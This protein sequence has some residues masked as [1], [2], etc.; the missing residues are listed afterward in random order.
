[1]TSLER[2][3]FSAFLVEDHKLVR[4]GMRLLLNSDPQIRVMGEA[5]DAEDALAQLLRCQP[6]VVLIDLSLPGQSGTW[7][8]RQLRENRPDLRFLVVSM[9]DDPDSVIEAI[10]AGASGYIVKSATADELRAAVRAVASGGSFLH[11]E[12]A[13][14]V[15]RQ[16]RAPGD[17]PGPGEDP[18]LTAREREI[19]AIIAH[20]LNNRQMAERLHL[21]VSAVKSHLRSLFRKFA[22]SDRTQLVVEAIRQ[23]Y[24][25]SGGDQRRKLN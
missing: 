14:A 21:S 1:M 4:E 2:N 18:D 8:I 7:C 23:G 11:S 19:L 22:V 17:P 12:V 6:D 13:D 3:V 25:H 20:G 9:Y 24:L 10:H 15:L 5:A 16:F